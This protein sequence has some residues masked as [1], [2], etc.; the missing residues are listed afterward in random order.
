MSAD[1]DMF[2]DFFPAT[3]NPNN[4]KFESEDFG[5]T[6]LWRNCGGKVHLCTNITLKHHG[7]FGFPANIYRQLVDN[8]GIA[9][10][11]KKGNRLEDM[12]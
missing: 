7:W 12:V 3:I 2:Y 8:A 4:R 1:K 10:E 11:E 6:T 5:F 9:K